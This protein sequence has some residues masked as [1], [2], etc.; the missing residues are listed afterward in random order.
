M[1][2]NRS[3]FVVCVKLGSGL[4]L[5]AGGDRSGIATAEV[6]NMTTNV[7]TMTGNMSFEPTYAQ[8]SVGPTGVGKHC[9]N[10]NSVLLLVET[11]TM[12][13]KS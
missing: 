11:S 4:I 6:L 7:W 12:L 9:I 5:A 8:S 13:P 2:A 10:Q 1:N 3:R